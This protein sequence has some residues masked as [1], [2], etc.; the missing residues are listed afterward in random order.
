[1][2]HVLPLL[3]ALLLAPRSAPNAAEIPPQERPHTDCASPPHA[4]A[5]AKPPGSSEVRMPGGCLE[6]GQG[7]PAWAVPAFDDAIATIAATLRADAGQE[8]AHRWTAATKG[9]VRLVGLLQKITPEAEAE[10]RL[11]ADGEPIWQRALRADD[12]IPLAFDV[13]AYDLAQGSTVDLVVVVEK[14]SP[15]AAVTTGLQ[16]VPEPF[17][18][19]WRVDLPTGYPDFGEAEKTVLRQKGQ[20]ILQDIRAASQ[21]GQAEFVIPPGD[22]LFHARWSQASTL[23]GLADLEIKAEGVTFWFEPPMLHG[24]LLEDC[25]RVT[26][27]GLTIDF[28]LPC[29]FQARVLEVDRD[30]NTIR[31]ALLPGYEPRQ[32]HGELET[33]GARTFL[34]YDDRGRFINH[35]HAPGR[36]RRAAEEGIVLCHDLQRSGI[37]DRL[38]PGDYVVATIRTGAA[39]RSLGCADLRFEEVNIW[40]SPGIAVYENGGEGG[41]VYRRVRATR[42]PHTNRLQAFGADVFHL[43]GTDRGP[44]LD[45]CEAAYSG[46][47]VLNIHGSFGRVVQ[48]AGSRRYY[49][50]GAYEV[51]DTVEFRD[52]NSVAL[53]GIARVVAAQSAPDGPSRAIN[54]RYQATS[55]SLVELDQP[56]DLPELSLVV[57]DGKRSATGWVVRNCWFHDDFQRTL[58]NGSPGGLIENTT[59]QNVGQGLCVQFETWGPWMEGPFARDLVI[60]QNRFLD[61]PPDGSAI[62]VSMHPPGGGSNRRRFQVQPVTN[63]TITGNYFGPTS[64]V[65]LCIHNVDGLQITGNSVDHPASAAMPAGLSNAATVNWLYLQDCQNVFLRANPDGPGSQLEWHLPRAADGP[66]DPG[67]D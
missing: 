17:V 52:A 7:K 6:D 55:E 16:V 29:W 32:A 36:W 38:K 41:H 24:L 34:F 47:D 5:A 8:A 51:G 48:R 45:R 25:R 50:Q 27:R 33:E 21:A 65:P 60:R 12:S 18:S 31:A 2:K 3:V 43:A 11:L 22:Y 53:L 58:I 23:Q 39:L 67:R 59:L 49:L 15:A 64:G 28:T 4:A 10:I 20:D 42:R 46:D 61:A 40:S 62:C 54:D 9:S 26:L 44:T 57:L 66:R 37:P 35:R 30:G 14:D 13:V 56:L 1:M 63:M 19:R